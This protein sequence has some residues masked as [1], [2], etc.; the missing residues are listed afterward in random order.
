MQLIVERGLPTQV[1]A[2]VAP[3]SPVNTAREAAVKAD[4]SGKAKKKK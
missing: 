3:P 2:G 4:N 1:K